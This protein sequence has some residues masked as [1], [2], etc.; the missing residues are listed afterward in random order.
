MNLF[1]AYLLGSKVV[2]PW[3]I[4]DDNLQTQKCRWSET[5]RN[6]DDFYDNY[7]SKEDPDGPFAIYDTYDAGFGTLNPE[8]AQK[9]CAAGLDLEMLKKVGNEVLLDQFLQGAGVEKVGDRL[10]VI[11]FIR[12]AP[13]TAVDVAQQKST[14]LADDSTSSHEFEKWLSGTTSVTGG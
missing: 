3:K 7:Q 8:V 14:K 6:A 10:R 12:D 9:L 5:G 11:F 13:S 1:H 4:A 2:R